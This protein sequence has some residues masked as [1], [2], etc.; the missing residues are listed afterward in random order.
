MNKRIR[1]LQIIARLN[2]GG[3]AILVTLLTKRLD[4]TR[5]DPRLVAG[6]EN[7]QEGNYLDLYGQTV[8]G[9]IAIPELT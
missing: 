3:P 6:K 8:P 5:Y 1:V 2:I 7:P 4:P 9:L